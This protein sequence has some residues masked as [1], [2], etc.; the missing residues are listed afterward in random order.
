MSPGSWRWCH[1]AP[2]WRPLGHLV[3]LPG[4]RRLAGRV[5]TYVADHRYALP[6]GTPAC[7]P[8]HLSDG[9]VAGTKGSA[10]VG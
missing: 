7:A 2:L 8:T 3:T 1:G 10:S 5:Y 6:G 9:P 4:V